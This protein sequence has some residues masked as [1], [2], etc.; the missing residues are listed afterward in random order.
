M[1]TNSYRAISNKNNPVAPLSHTVNIRSFSSLE[2]IASLIIIAIPFLNILDQHLN[3]YIDIHYISYVIKIL[4]WI[5]T[6]MIMYWF[7]GK[8]KGYFV[9]KLFIIAYV[10]KIVYYVFAF[11]HYNFNKDSIIIPLLLIVLFEKR[12]LRIIL[13][14]FIE[15]YK[16]IL[17][18]LVL[19]TILPFMDIHI[20]TSSGMDR[21]LGIWENSKP[22]AYFLFG[23]I[24]LFSRRWNFLLFLLSLFLYLLIIFIGS[25]GVIIAGFFFIVFQITQYFFG[26]AERKANLLY[27]AQILILVS[28]SIVALYGGLFDPFINRTYT[29]MQ[30]LVAEDI[31]NPAYGHGRVYL[32]QIIFSE[33]ERFNALEWGIGRSSTDMGNLFE[34]MIGSRTF[35]HN[36]FV[37]ILYTNGL[38]GLCI[39]LYYLFIYPFRIITNRINKLALMNLLMAIFILAATTG[40]YNYYAC[41]LISPCITFIYHDGG[42][43]RT[44]KKRKLLPQFNNAY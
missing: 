28:I 10:S 20:V 12:N 29:Y 15:R 5:L 43:T 41:Y 37:T 17:L 25:R 13:Q 7:F 11:N 35:P 36:D 42:N 39:Y 24:V 16:Y 33:I 19:L 31:S 4:G 18:I 6:F 22:A 14:R 9:L 34:M 8:I 38:I 27:F 2:T 21:V 23:F 44:I 30:P 40:F 32:N 1:K 3:Y 26:I